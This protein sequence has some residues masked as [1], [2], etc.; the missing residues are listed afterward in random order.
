MRKPF[1]VGCL[2]SALVQSHLFG[3]STTASLEKVQ[4]SEFFSDESESISVE[5][6]DFEEDQIDSR[7]LFF[8]DAVISGDVLSFESE[9]STPT[10]QEGNTFVPAEELISRL[11][12]GVNYTHVNLKPH[13]HASFHGNL[14]GMQGIYEYRPMDGL[15]GA[16]KL[17]WREGDTHGSAGKRS[18]LYVD[19]Q[20]RLGYTFSFHNEDWLLTLYS[21][22]GYRHFGQKLSPKGEPSIKFRYNEFYIPVGAI[23]DYAVNTWF[24]VGLGFTWMP[25]IYPTVE[26]E[27]LKG[28]RWIIVN[29]LSNFSIELPLTFSLTPSKRFFLIFNPFYEYW[30]DGH[31]TAK[32]TDGTRLGLPGNTYNFWGADLNFVYSF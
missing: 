2:L 31:S 17:A 21:G 15:Y 3:S 5:E 26:I 12:I 13:G 27:P 30:R 22:L 18:L 24:D 16:A 8:D 14:G 7:D 28:A 6:V 1:A 19:A 32:L 29:E 4:F 25:Q 10:T 9:S 20:E 23:A 11:Q